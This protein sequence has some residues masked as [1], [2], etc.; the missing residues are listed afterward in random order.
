MT[1]YELNQIIQTYV[2]SDESIR[3]ECVKQILADCTKSQV[4]WAT[5]NVRALGY[6][7]ALEFIGMMERLESKG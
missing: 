1:T 6:Q 2:D 7:F 4:A 5:F 3:E